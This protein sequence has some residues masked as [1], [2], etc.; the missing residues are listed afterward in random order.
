MGRVDAIVC[1]GGLIRGGTGDDRHIARAVASAMHAVATAGG[2]GPAMPV[3]FGVITA[4]NAEQAEARAGGTKGNKGSE[5]ME[6]AL[7]ALG[8]MRALALE[9]A[10]GGARTR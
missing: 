8:A 1:L 10:P 6:A 7:A 9:P 5:A 3:A 4:G 2:A